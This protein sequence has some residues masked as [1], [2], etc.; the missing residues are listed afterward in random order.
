MNATYFILSDLE[1]L[2]DLAYK[3]AKNDVDDEDAGEGI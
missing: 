3:E 1:I 2:L